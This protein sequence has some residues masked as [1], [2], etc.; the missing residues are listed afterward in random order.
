MMAK[1]FYKIIEKLLHDGA[2][3]TFVEHR[4][5]KIGIRTAELIVQYMML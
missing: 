1:K 4:V 5:E 2:N 3:A